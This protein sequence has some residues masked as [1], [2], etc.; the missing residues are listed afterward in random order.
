MQYRALGN[1]KIQASVIGFGTWAIGGW[2]WGGTDE[3]KSVDALRSAIDRGI[4]L[5]DTA[6]MYGYGLSEE[7]VGKA[8]RGHRDNVVLATKCGVRWTKGELEPGKGEFY[9]YG[10]TSGFGTETDHDWK[11]Y[12]CLHPDSIR[13]EVEWSLQ[14]LG[15]DYIDLYQ[16]HTQESTIPIEETM[17]TLLDLKREGKIRAIGV[18]NATPEQLRRYMA[19]GR[20]DVSQE[21]FSFIDRGIEENGILDLCRQKNASLLPYSPLAM[22]LLT[23]K[24][25]PD[26]HFPDTDIRSTMER[27]KPDNIT[28][29]NAMLQKLEP[30]AQRRQLTI[31]QLIIAWT[32]TFY[33]KTH[34][35]C[36]ARTPEQVLENAVSGDVFLNREEMEFLA[37]LRE[38]KFV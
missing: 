36:G 1:T 23:G 14:R 17:G 38:E 8:I 15:T 9:L 13:K 16:T 35:L 33:N 29:V 18:S 28:R 7:I 22:G 32:I 2:L 20:V 34:I 5:I 12:I 27:F 25:A 19:V 21:R 26:R 10:S 24:M 6:P 37:G 4:N 31:G 3:K 11:V 30:I